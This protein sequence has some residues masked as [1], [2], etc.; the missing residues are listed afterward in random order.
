MDLRAQLTVFRRH[1]LLILQAIILA[2]VVAGLVAHSQKPTYE[3]TAQVL[4]VPGDPSE[5]ITPVGAPTDITQYAS[6]QGQLVTNP[7]V[8][9]AAAKKLNSSDPGGLAQQ[10]RVSSGAILYITATDP[11]AKRAAQIANAFAQG[12]LD[13][14]RATA[15]DS[16]KRT[17][18]QL[19]TQAASL[20]AQIDAAASNNTD[21]LRAQYQAVYS[22]YITA[23]INLSLAGP[24]AR[25]LAQATP[26]ASPT[27]TPLIQTVL[28]GAVAGLLL[29]AGGA[30]LREQLDDRVRSREDAAKA[31][32]GMPILAE[33]VSD[34]RVVRGIAAGGL[35]AAMLSQLGE[36][37]RALRTAIMFYGVRSE[38]RR[39]LV[40]SPG[41]GDG[42]TLVS[43]LLAAAFAQAGFRTLLISADLRR[44]GVEQLL[45]P[46]AVVGPGL[47]DALLLGPSTE[48][49]APG[50]VKTALAAHIQTTD[51][52]NLTFLPAGSISPNPGE[53]LGSRRMDGLLDEL[54]RS[55]DILILDSAP[56]LGVADTRPLAEKADGVI[57]VTTVGQ[58]KRDLIRAR[59]TLGQADVKWLGLVLNRAADSA[60]SAY[61]TARAGTGWRNR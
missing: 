48:H 24:N 37:A 17:A 23:T 12:Y 39:I 58:S 25:L 18:A 46:A 19:K 34:R 41:S 54:S 11:D 28:F 8:S 59:E 31:S 15:V 6:L 45:G 53:L 36:A 52:A 2:G 10:V 49:S 16:L 22:Q 50:D 14:S 1:W 9:R 61:G 44:P 3:A 55:H 33:V 21:A 51:Q 57:L 35:E 30:Y 56:L 29:G 27:G 13:Y 42:K 40:T 4:L 60:E 7:A 26:S 5:S 38:E 47:T 20:Q 43:T 32:G